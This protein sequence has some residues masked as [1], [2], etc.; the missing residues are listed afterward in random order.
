MERRTRDRQF[1]KALVVGIGVSAV[2]HGAVLEFGG[3]DI[4]T[5]APPPDLEVRAVLTP[6][7]EAEPESPLAETRLESAEVAERP[8]EERGDE[9]KAAPGDAAV[10]IPDVGR[11]DMTDHRVP[12]S[13]S[14]TRMASAGLESSQPAPRFSAGRSD[15]G[16]SV[17]KPDRRSLFGSFAGI[18]IRAGRGCL[19]PSTG[20]ISAA[21]LSGGLRG[22]TGSAIP[23][24]RGVPIGIRR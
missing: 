19:I 8:A 13:R 7:D 18:T 17:E 2:L 10:D 24:N 20:T 21:G 9:P 23:N 1:G 14:A 22:P 6:P 16:G 12:M 5:D 11:R 3:L 4:E 15:R